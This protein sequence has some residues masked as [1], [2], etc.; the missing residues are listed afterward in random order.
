MIHVFDLLYL[1]AFRNAT[2]IVLARSANATRQLVL[3]TQAERKEVPAVR[4]NTWRHLTHL[5]VRKYQVYD[6]VVRR[7]A[8]PLNGKAFH[9]S[10][11]KE[12]T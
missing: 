2:V 4:Q 8:F 3:R 1:N 11:C 7:D 5:N 9:I 10:S 6:M 12:Y